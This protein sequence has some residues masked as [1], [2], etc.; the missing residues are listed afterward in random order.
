MTLV[1]IVS[2][3]L[4]GADGV[5]V[6]AAKWQW[7][8]QRLGY[9]V[10]T[11]AGEGEADAIVPGL[12]AGRVV[13][14]RAAP[15][16]ASG[17]IEEAL[18][19]V[20]L[21]VVENL[22]SLPF[23]PPALAAVAGALA[24]RP[25]I[26][27][28]HDLAWQRPSTLG[29]GFGPAAP[30]PPDD[31]SWAH[32]TI[33]DLSR[34]QLAARGVEATT[35]RNAF[36]AVPPTGDREATRASLGVGPSDVVVL[37][38]TR[39]IP[40]KGI[41]AGITLA[42]A[43]GGIYWLLGD[44]EEGYGP[45]LEKLL[46]AARAPIVRGPRP[47]MAGHAGIEHAYAACD[48]VAFGSTWEG[49]GNPPIEASLHRRPVAVGRYPVAGELRALGFRWF[50][51]DDPRG[52]AMWLERPDPGLLDANS[53]AVIEHLSLED[54]PARLRRVI[55]RAGWG[56]PLSSAALDAVAAAPHPGRQ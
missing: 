51:I 40:R 10:R 28:H 18:A 50:D 48:V 52:V 33:N 36:A 42:E 38:P 12:A 23:N 43:L 11:I 56:P 9:D 27:R 53:E 49:F 55:E 24:G 5:S 35:I 13:T 31:P 26:L 6:E 39:A 1:A 30:P 15:P 29:P 25:A 17:E 2:F 16:L 14:G 41:A 3:R 46:A 7:A 20:E 32:V 4:G 34:R 22:C 54:L 21:T 44:A 8:L 19:G 37:Q 45:H 47:P